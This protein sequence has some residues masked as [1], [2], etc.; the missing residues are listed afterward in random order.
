MKIYRMTVIILLLLISL[1]LL[2]GEKVVLIDLTQVKNLNV[3]EEMNLNLLLENQSSIMVCIENGQQLSDKRIPFKLIS[4][5]IDAPLYLLSSKH[6]KDMS[7]FIDKNMVVYQDSHQIIVNDPQFS[8]DQYI[9]KNIQAVKL[10]KSSRVYKNQKLAYQK[11]IRSLLPVD[12]NVINAINADSIAYFI[13][14]L[15]DFQT[16]YAFHPNRFQVS[17]WIRDQ[18]IRM[19]YTG[20]YVDSFYHANYGVWQKNVIAVKPG[21]EL[22]DQYVLIGGHHD[23]ILNSGYENSMIFAPGADDNASGSAAVLEIARA[24]KQVNYENKVS[25]RFCTYAMEELGL[26]GSKY[27]AYVS[28]SN[29]IKIRAMINNDMIASQISPNWVAH[30]QTYTTGMFL[31]DLAIDFIEEMPNM[32]YVVSNTNTSGSDSWSYWQYGYPSI[33]LAESEFSPYYHS[34]ND[35]I[36]YCN[37]PYAQQMVKLAASM[38]MYMAEIPSTP[39]NFFIRDAGNGSELQAVW[40]EI[41]DQG[42]VSYQL[43]V[44]NTE[45]NESTT[46]TTNESSYLIN[47]LSADVEYEIALTAKIGEKESISVIRT[48][49]PAV[50]PEMVDSF[51]IIAHWNN[52]QINWYPNSELDISGY[53]IYQ[54]TNEDELGTEISYV[55][56]PANTYQYT[57]TDNFTLYYYR[58]K[59]VDQQGNMSEMTEAIAAR[60]FTMSHGILILDDTY[61]GNGSVSLPSDQQVDAFYSSLF[62]DYDVT[63][64]EISSLNR[65]INIFD[66]CA[67]SLVVYHR[68]STNSSDIIPYTDALETY[69]NEGGKLIISAYKASQIFSYY[70]GYPATFNSGLFVR[71]YLKIQMSNF[72]TSARFKYANALTLGFADIYCDS[73]KTHPNMVYRVKDVESIS[74]SSEGTAIYSYQSDYDSGST[75]AVMDGSPVGVL[76]NGNDFK[77]LTLSFPLYNMKDEDAQ[78]MIDRT[79]EIWGGVQS[80][81]ETPQTQNRIAVLHHNYPNP[82]NPSTTLSYTL[83]QGCDVT[84]NIYNI[85]GQIIRSYHQGFQNQGLHEIVWNGKDEQQKEMSSGVYF[86]QLQAGS[87]SESKKMILI[88]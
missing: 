33:F 38:L 8:I 40:S 60:P 67:Y 12:Q 19:G 63:H 23:S 84:L 53:R 86:Y 81:E 55:N 61:N 4:D 6:H 30:L 57:P 21:T 2:A 85:K 44:T 69:L 17:E 59:A 31:K 42:N 3:L 39:E 47:N 54:S 7:Q 28:A 88:K 51:N 11:D 74:A 1:N 66:L 79:I 80:N 32:D 25:I 62:T 46:Y 43:V 41:P 45:N 77:T 68:N 18:F 50:L 87:S 5:D 49:I 22:V 29:E 34:T 27:D 10:E 83:K 58:I 13:Q 9:K 37:M 70:P 24:M 16:R 35:I 20:A 82:F 72:N 64:L 71:D 26:W 48:A 75:Q 36:E 56:H 65:D 14:S 52:I 76:Y 78:A 15:Q 73:L